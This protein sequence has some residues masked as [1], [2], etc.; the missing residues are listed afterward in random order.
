MLVG[1]GLRVL[2]PDARRPPPDRRDP[3]RARHDRRPSSRSTRSRSPCPAHVSTGQELPGLAALPPAEPLGPVLPPDGA[4]RRRPSSSC[5]RRGRSVGGLRRRL[6]AG[7]RGCCCAGRSCPRP[8]SS[9]GRSRATSTCCVRARRRRAG[10]PGSLSIRCR[11][12]GFVSSRLPH[13]FADRRWSAAAAVAVVLQPVGAYPAEINPV[14]STSGLAGTGGIPG[15]RETGQVDRREHAQRH[16]LM[17]IGPSMANI[18]GS[19]AHRKALR[20]VGQPEPAAPQPVLRA[21]RQPRPTRC[22]TETSSTWS[23]TVSPP[24]RSPF[25]AE[26]AQALRSTGTTAR[27]STPR[28][29]APVRTGRR[30]PVII[31]YEV[32]P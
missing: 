26:R 9:S 16:R 6:P 10:C 22:A 18:V 3:A 2:R 29:S 11:L 8:S 32:R 20:A 14:P 23:G 12:P 13:E 5:W 7:G 19:T 27:P 28:R 15:G 21:D 17:T 1:G 24:S 30:E 31:V 25:F 4:R